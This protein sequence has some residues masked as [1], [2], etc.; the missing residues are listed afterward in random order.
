MSLLSSWTPDPKRTRTA[1]RSYDLISVPDVV[2][3]SHAFRLDANVSRRTRTTTQ[4]LNAMHSRAQAGPPL[5]KIA[6]GGAGRRAIEQT[7]LS[8][9]P[10]TNRHRKIQEGLNPRVKSTGQA[11]RFAPSEGSTVRTC[12]D[13]FHACKTDGPSGFH[14]AVST[15][16]PRGRRPGPCKA[17][18][19][20][21]GASRRRNRRWRL[22][23]LRLVKTQ[24]EKSRWLLPKLLT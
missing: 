23:R 8:L 13:R 4:P 3:S 11:E 21:R 17:V 6:G 5:E 18:V 22:L 20:P 14:S 15:T 16:S 19:K 12:F 2:P 1:A 10:T 9:R 24:M 7:I